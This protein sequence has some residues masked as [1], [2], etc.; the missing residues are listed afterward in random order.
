MDSITSRGLY[1]FKETPCILTLKVDKMA[2]LDLW[3]QHLGHPLKQVTKLIPDIGFKRNDD[4][5]N[6]VLMFI[7]VQNRLAKGF[8]L[9]I[10]ELLTYSN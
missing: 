9:V 2:S 3:Y 8:L 10:L 4:H 7:N 1:Y 5:F 6:S